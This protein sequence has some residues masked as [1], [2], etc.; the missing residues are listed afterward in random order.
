MASAATLPSAMPSKTTSPRVMV[1]FATAMISGT[2]ATARLIGCEKSTRFCTQI[3]TPS[4]P[5]MP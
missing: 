1:K 2:P 3:R 4:T 5:I